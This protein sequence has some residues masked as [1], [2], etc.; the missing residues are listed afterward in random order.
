MKGPVIL[1]EQHLLLQQRFPSPSMDCVEW[2]P[3]VSLSSC[4]AV[5]C[6]W[7]EY[8]LIP[9]G[10]LIMFSEAVVFLIHRNVEQR[11]LFGCLQEEKTTSFYRCH[12]V[13]V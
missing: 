1:E 6:P 3:S 7:F 5:K 2:D 4:S 8:L 9:C 13:I 10:R 12:S 11:G